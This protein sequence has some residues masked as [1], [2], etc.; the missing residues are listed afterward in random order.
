MS[1]L[2]ESRHVGDVARLRVNGSWR[3]MSLT[4]VVSASL[5][6]SVELCVTTLFVLGFVWLRSVNGV[7]AWVIPTGAGALVAESWLAAFALWDGARLVALAYVL[8]P[9]LASL[10][11][12]VADDTVATS[13]ALL[14]LLHVATRDLFASFP[15]PLVS[16]NAG[17]LGAMLLCSRL[18]SYEQVFAVVLLGVLAFAVWPLLLVQLRRLV[19]HSLLALVLALTTLVFMLTLRLPSWVVHAFLALLATVNG[20]APIVFFHLQKLKMH[21]SGQWTEVMVAN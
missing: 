8:T 18:P 20:V 3:P 2:F 5:H 15:R 21:L 12:S 13:A 10:A 16:A 19:P 17:L 6:V 1:V 9:V 14:L 4:A 7:P 11:R